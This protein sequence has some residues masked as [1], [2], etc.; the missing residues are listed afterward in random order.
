MV[1]VRPPDQSGKSECCSTCGHESHHGQPC[2]TA[3]ELIVSHAAVEV[4]SL[5]PTEVAQFLLT[6]LYRI[7]ELEKRLEEPRISPLEQAGRDV[8]AERLKAAS[9]EF[10]ALLTH[11]L[12]LGQ[13]DERLL[14]ARAP[15]EQQHLHEKALSDGF[16]SGLLALGP[17]SDPRWRPPVQINAALADA[18]SFHLLKSPGET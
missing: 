17:P 2:T 6:L 15:E 1:Q 9:P 3:S 7:T 16:E 14:I 10:I 4:E 12:L 11:L 8:V 18:L 5:Q 13:A